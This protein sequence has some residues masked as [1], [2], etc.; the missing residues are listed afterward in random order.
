MATIPK[1]IVEEENLAPG[2]TIKL[3]IKKAKKSFLG[4]LKGIGP[5]KKE[6]EIEMDKDHDK[7]HY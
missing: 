5:W 1:E 6:Y 3:E 7:D 4:A 2:M